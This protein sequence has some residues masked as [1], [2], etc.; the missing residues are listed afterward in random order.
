MNEK[1]ADM[2]Q[3]SQMYEGTEPYIF[4]RNSGHGAAYLLYWTSFGIHKR[5]CFDWALLRL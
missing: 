4:I 2:A 3:N 5:C 1:Y